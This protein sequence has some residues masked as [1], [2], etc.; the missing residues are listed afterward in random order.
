MFLNRESGVDIH[1][2]RKRGGSPF[3]YGRKK[4][5]VNIFSYKISEVL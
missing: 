4:G 1:A 5:E 2:D 3:V